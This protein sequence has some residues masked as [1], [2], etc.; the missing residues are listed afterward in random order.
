MRKG[1]GVQLRVIAPRPGHFTTEKIVP[2]THCARGWT[3]PGPLWKVEKETIFASV[4]N[5][6]LK[7]WLTY[8][9]S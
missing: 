3:D 7:S 9:I 1:S 6:V 8:P 4:W 2:R 5:R